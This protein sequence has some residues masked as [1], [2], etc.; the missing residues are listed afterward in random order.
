MVARVTA[1]IAGLFAG[2]ILGLEKLSAV[3]DWLGLLDLVVQLS[4]VL[5]Q[6]HLASTSLEPRA[7]TW[8]A[9]EALSSV[10]WHLVSSVFVDRFAMVVVVAVGC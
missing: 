3:A 4:A 5:S 6:H 1:A 10:G 2:S 9:A 8:F 7:G